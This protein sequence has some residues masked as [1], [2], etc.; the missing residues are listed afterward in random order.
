MYSNEYFIVKSTSYEI[1]QKDQ[2]IIL[3][4]KPSFKDIIQSTNSGLNLKFL[5]SG[6]IKIL[7]GFSINL[8]WINIVWDEEV[9]QIKSTSCLNMVVVPDKILHIQS[10]TNKLYGTNQS[11]ESYELYIRIE[12][13]DEKIYNSLEANLEESFNKLE[14][15]TSLTKTIKPIGK[16]IILLNKIIKSIGEYFKMVFEKRGLRCEL[17]YRLRLPDSFNF[18]YHDDHILMILYFNES[19][20]L[21][22]NRI[23]YYQIEQKESIFLTDKKKLKL[24]VNMMKKSEKIWD[25]MKIAR[26]FYESD[27][28]NKITYVPMPFVKYKPE[29][30]YL[31][32]FD[33][34]ENDIFFYG[35][36]NKRRKAILNKLDKFFKIKISFGC[37]GDEKLLLI[38]NSKII[39]NLHYYDESGLETCRLNEILNYKKIIISENSNL[40]KENMELYKHLVIFVDEINE[41]LENINQLIKCISHYLKKSNYVK[42]VE[43]MEDNIDELEKKINKMI[44]V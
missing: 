11:N 28:K 17:I 27:F 10:E 33:E 13:F 2:V 6:K 9:S 44:V 19:H 25:Y 15:E 20:K 12:S 39:L 23:I 38:S 3:K 18:F 5:K 43:S 24:I 37:Y 22:P 35:N 7:I 40:D 34:C 1:K 41:D 14:I 4:F 29:P 16:I 31:I 30:K 21:L 36:L 26:C 42:F 8:D 32:N